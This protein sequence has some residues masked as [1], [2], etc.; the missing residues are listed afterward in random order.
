MFVLVQEEVSDT[1]LLLCKGADD[2]IFE[3]LSE[4]S[5]DAERLKATDTHVK[6]F[7]QEGLRTL[8]MAYRYSSLPTLPAYLLTNST[9]GGAR[10]RVRR[11]SRAT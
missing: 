2:V 11:I 7:A 5:T 1:I 4:D 6:E 8:V 9:K 3:R 10:G